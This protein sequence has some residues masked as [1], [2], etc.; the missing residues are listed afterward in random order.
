MSSLE[1]FYIQQWKNKQYERLV[2]HRVI[3]VKWATDIEDLD[4]PSAVKIPPEIELTDFAINNY[5]SETYGYLVLD[6]QVA[7][8]NTQE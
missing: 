3:L 7:M 8:T 4:L 1:W 5:L 2:Q 6:W